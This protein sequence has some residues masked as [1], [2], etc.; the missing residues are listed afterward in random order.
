M[1]DLNPCLRDS[2]HGKVLSE[3]SSSQIDLTDF[4][5]VAERF[6]IELRNGESPSVESFAISNEHLAKKIRRLFPILELIETDE[7]FERELTSVSSIESVIEQFLGGNEHRRLGD[8][9]ILKEIGRGGMGIVYLARQNSL[10]RLVALKLL[11]NSATFD[12]NRVARF[13]REARAAAALHHTNIVP[14]FEVGRDDGVS[15][16][17]MQYINARSMREFIKSMVRRSEK[18]GVLGSPISNLESHEMSTVVTPR[19]SDE[20]NEKQKSKSDLPNSKNLGSGIQSASSH[21]SGIPPVHFRAY[22]DHAARM[23]KQVADGLAHAHS[24]GVL[25]RDIKP[26]NLLIDDQLNVWITDFGLAKS[27]GSPDITTSGDVIGTLAYMSPEQLVGEADQRSDV[28]ALGLTLYELLALQP[29][30]SEKNRASLIFQVREAN[31]PSL[32]S[33]N[34]E[35]PID[36][37]TIVHKC[38][39]QE[40]GERYQSASDVARELQ[41]FLDGLPI[42]ARPVSLPLRF[43]SW[44]LRNPLVSGLVSGLILIL[45]LSS[46]VATL[47]WHQTS[48]ALAEAEF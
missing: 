26:G 19:D 46:G 6:L 30:Y 41:R 34:P 40:P 7:A 25:H 44:C 24:K 17:V 32:Q 27:Q 28:F 20:A 8:F 33:L 14:I 38:L 47:Q 45:L 4:E 36:L 10:G 21:V 42:L 48:M 37:S 18:K 43:K 2:F 22:C 11:P 29:A 23:A 9:Q 39:R 1:L 13:Q 15:Y 31:P 12:D 5:T 3:M 35:I 16:Y